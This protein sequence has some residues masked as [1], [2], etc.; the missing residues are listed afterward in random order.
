MQCSLLD[1]SLPPFFFIT[2][3]Y[4]NNNNVSIIV[5]VYLFECVLHGVDELWYCYA[6]FIRGR[7]LCGHG[8]RRNHS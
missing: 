7:E 5:I 6:L 1:I 8:R 2:S 3:Y 4:N